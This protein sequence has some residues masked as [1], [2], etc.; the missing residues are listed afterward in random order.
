MWYQWSHLI[1]SDSHQEGIWA[2]YGCIHL[3]PGFKPSGLNDLPEP[4]VTLTYFYTL[5]THH[6]PTIQ[7]SERHEK[8]LEGTNRGR[9][10]K[11]HS[12]LYFHPIFIYCWEL[13]SYSQVLREPVSWGEFCKKCC[14]FNS[15]ATTWLSIY[16]DRHLIV[17]PIV[18]VVLFW[19]VQPFGKVTFH[20]YLTVSV[21]FGKRRTP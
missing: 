8:Q 17:C 3:H 11:I 1:S 2:H 7:T 10:F 4:G 15:E 13:S 9:L 19:P 18:C 20:Q 12:Q 16:L 21:N 5:K 14:S 6:S